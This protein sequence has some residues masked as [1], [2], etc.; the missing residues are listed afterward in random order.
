MRSLKFKWSLTL[1]VT[2]LVGIVLV[3]LLATQINVSEYKRFR[4]EEIE[5][6]VADSAS[7]FY[8]RFGTWDGLDNQILNSAFRRFRNN[9]DDRPQRTPFLVA[10]ADGVIVKP[11][12]NYNMGDFALADDINNGIP[13]LVNNEQVGTLMITTPMGFD[14][15][16]VR[17][18]Q[19]TNN[20]LLLGAGGAV[21]IAVLLGVLLSRQFLRPLAELTT[22]IENVKQG[23]FDQRV[24]IRSQ[25]ELGELAHAFN[26]MGEELQRA[27]KLRR[28]M[29]ADIAHDLRTP[30]TVISGYLEGLRDGSLQPTQTRFDT[31]FQEAQLLKRLIE[32]L[33]TLSLADAG[34]LQLVYQRVAPQDLLEQVVVS[35]TPLADAQS[36]TLDMNISEYLPAIDIDRDRM[37]QVLGNLVSNSLRFTPQD[38]KITLSAMASDTNIILTVQD[39]GSGIAS[40]YMENI[41]ARFYRASESRHQSDNESGLG[42]AIAKSIVTAHGGQISAKSKLGMGT[43]ITIGLPINQV[44]V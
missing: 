8:K 17:F 36:V 18:L 44:E 33:R 34:E 6:A 25:D 28:Q 35:F 27:N 5:L 32:D 30:L 1:V 3:G 42:L 15:S 14:E 10:D 4:N 39:T 9:N 37:V 16:E 29:T 13:I 22:A 2:S 21:A 31:L 43:T 12:G 19:R 41:F 40:E 26:Q 23:K 7:N 38:G 20:A 24:P 11:S